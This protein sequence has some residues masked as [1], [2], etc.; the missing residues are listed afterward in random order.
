MSRRTGGAGIERLR[1]V[2]LGVVE[3][4]VTNNAIVLLRDSDHTHPCG[5]MIDVIVDDL[6]PGKV[7][8]TLEH[9]LRRA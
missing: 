8:Q 4:R 6:V 2:L 1:D 5:V 9:D 7:W 3:L